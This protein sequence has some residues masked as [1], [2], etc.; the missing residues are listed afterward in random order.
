MTIIPPK[1]LLVS[2]K[3]IEVDLHSTE[4]MRGNEGG[5]S[6]DGE[7]RPAALTESGFG[8]DFWK[9]LEE[10][11][12]VRKA[13]EQLD[14]DDALCWSVRTI[15]EK[16]ECES[17][18][19]LQKITYLEKEL[20][21][22]END[23]AYLSSLPS[24]HYVGDYP[25]HMYVRENLASEKVRWKLLG[26]ASE[27]EKRMEIEDVIFEAVMNF[28]E[29]QLDEGKST[30][31]FVERSGKELEKQ[32]R[33]LGPRREA[34]RLCG[35]V[36]LA[37]VEAQLGE[38]DG[39]LAS[40]AAGQGYSLQPGREMGQDC[41]IEVCQEQTGGGTEGETECIK[42]KVVGQYSNEIHF[43]VKMTT[44]MGKLKKSYS[45]RV[46]VPVTS[47]RFLFDGKR[48]N[49]D[50]TP[51]SLEMKQDDEI[52]VYH[53]Q[54]GGLTSPSVPHGK[55]CFG[56]GDVRHLVQQCILARKRS[57][58]KHVVRGMEKSSNFVGFVRVGPPKMKSRSKRCYNC[59]VMG[60]LA[61][62]CWNSDR[63]EDSTSQAESEENGKM[64][65]D[66][67]GRPREGYWNLGDDK[68]NHSQSEWD[69]SSD[70]SDRPEENA[71]GS[72]YSP[73]PPPPHIVKPRMDL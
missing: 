1:N 52:E 59:G 15:N 53:E 6:D 66:K 17:A 48:I 24:Y 69:R 11:I 63:S 41:V 34:R 16:F 26:G 38:L 62:E 73:P 51:N 29:Q 32:E 57:R 39:W 67:S 36:D 30:T 20:S 70:E 21:S 61:R 4:P 47:L 9:G 43:R 64:W 25:P 5:M 44:A 55:K 22:F 49:D 27:L 54:T 8:D 60:H 12:S 35:E 2:E 14:Q 72:E 18:I 71:M 28:V 46:G 3:E 10:F 13:K 7:C 31:F 45:E 58:K 33:H 40:N 42:L 19:E 56:C 68:Y 23:G 50:E 37:V 65:Y